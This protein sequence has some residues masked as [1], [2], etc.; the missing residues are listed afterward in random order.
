MRSAG[1]KESKVF[2]FVNKKEAKNFDLLV[3]AGEISADQSRKSFFVTF[4]KK[5]TASLL[6]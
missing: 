2:S 6:F 3:R 1:L 5:V 4:F